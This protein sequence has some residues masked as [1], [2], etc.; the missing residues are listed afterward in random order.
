VWKI[1]WGVYIQSGYSKVRRKEREHLEELGKDC[2]IR[3]HC[4]LKKLGASLWNGLSWHSVRKITGVLEMVMKNTFRKICGISCLAQKLI[5][6]KSQSVIV[7]VTL[8]A[9]RQTDITKLI[10]AFAISFRTCIIK[11]GGSE[12]TGSVERESGTTD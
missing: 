7:T 3:V 5:F 6:R 4:T 9:D 12:K 1:Q 8:R 11:S 10:L 2:R